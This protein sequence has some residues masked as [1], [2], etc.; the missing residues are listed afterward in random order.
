MVTNKYEQIKTKYY[1]KCL[2]KRE[3]EKQGNSTIILTL[4]VL[5]PSDLLITNR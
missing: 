3:V 2:S 4:A 5:Q 1:I